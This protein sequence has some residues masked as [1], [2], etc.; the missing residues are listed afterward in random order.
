[1]QQSVIDE[2]RNAEQEGEERVQAAMGASRE[3]IRLC[4]E[5]IARHKDEK[6]K[7]IA[8]AVRAKIA[9]AEARSDETI[10]SAA[11]GTFAGRDDMLA[12]AQARRD[13]ALRMLLERIV[14]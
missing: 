2:I 7:E 1:M 9:E 14:G 4:G 5:E 12:T 3:S 13:E 6:S 11:S 10:A 8:E